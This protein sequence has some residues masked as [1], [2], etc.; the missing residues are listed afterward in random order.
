ME[1]ITSTIARNLQ[2]IRKKQ[3]MTLQDL[4][5]VTGVSKSM[6]GEIEREA[7]NPTITVLWKIATG[8]KLPLAD[9]LYE[10]GADVQLK[11]EPEW[12]ILHDGNDYT[13]ALIFPYNES[14][15]FEVY[16]F[17]FQ[18]HTP[19]IPK[20]P[21]KG[22]AETIIVYE[23]ELTLLV[24]GQAYVLKKGD[25]FLFEASYP[26]AYQNNGDVPAKAY[27]FIRYSG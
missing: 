20:S 8:L 16:H 23:G 7:S 12:D 11:R 1:N 15:R 26:Y 17:T 27:S 4:A 18:P 21:S 6:L 3:Q 14:R 10:Q 25:S 24:A 5:E 22:V 2:T 19:L 13:A 9:L